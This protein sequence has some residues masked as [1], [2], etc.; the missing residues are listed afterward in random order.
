MRRRKPRISSQS[1][2]AFVLAGEE[3]HA[4]A[5]RRSQRRSTSRGEDRHVVVGDHTALARPGVDESWWV[6]GGCNIEDE[7]DSEPPHSVDYRVELGIT[8]LLSKFNG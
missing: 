5:K 1:V 3:R 6:A 8:N 4:V 7:L 2:R